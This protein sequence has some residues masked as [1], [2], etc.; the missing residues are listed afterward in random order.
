MRKALLSGMA[1]ALLVGMPAA[2]RAAFP[3]PSNLA[4]AAFSTDMLLKYRFMASQGAAP[5]KMDAQK[6][7]DLESLLGKVTASLAQNQDAPAFRQRLEAEVR[8]P[9]S[10]VQELPKQE[11][12]D[13][14]IGCVTKLALYAQ[15]LP[16]NIPVLQLDKQ[17]TLKSF[18]ASQFFRQQA[19][20]NQGS[21][22]ESVTGSGFFIT[23]QGHLLT[24][25]HVVAGRSVVSIL[26]P[27]MTEPISAQ[28]LATDVDNDLAL[29][30]IE[31]QTKPLLL[32]QGQALA[33]QAVLAAGFPKVSSSGFT[34]KYSTGY[35]ISSSGV[36]A[37]PERLTFS[38][39]VDHGSSG[40]PL[41]DNSGNLLG[42]V[43]GMF[44][45]PASQNP[46]LGIAVQNDTVRRFLWANRV[47]F[48]DAAPGSPRRE[49]D[50]SVVLILAR[51]A[52]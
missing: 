36:L 24:N 14:F 32:A 15:Y 33:G 7:A 19:K 5:M 2:A 8:G 45:L 11:Q 46:P 35:V 21:Q 9:L 29:L 37:E 22:F 42:V 23:E 51:V 1:V 18:L 12:V 34:H 3:I 44:E 13:T 16:A 20:R 43:F 40:G 27:R 48:Q 26:H 25:N 50:E 17:S 39:P 31:Y 47:P 52:K 6:I 30:K 10:Q 28:V 41:V 4:C 38:A 49:L